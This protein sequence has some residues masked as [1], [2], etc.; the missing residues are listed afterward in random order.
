VTDTV[1]E[2]ELEAALQTY[3][4]AVGLARSGVKPGHIV[5]IRAIL[6]MRS[7]SPVEP[8]PML[9]FCPR[10]HLQHIDEPDER[11][12]DWTNPPHRSHLC[13]GCGCIWRPADV[14]TV[15]VAAIETKGKADN[16][17]AGQPAASPVDTGV[18]ERFPEIRGWFF[19]KLD[20]AQRKQFF[21]AVLNMR[22]DDEIRDRIELQ[23]QILRRLFEKPPASPVDGEVVERLQTGEDGSITLDNRSVQRLMDMNLLHYTEKGWFVGTWAALTAMK[24]NDRGALNPL[25]WAEIALADRTLG[26]SFPERDDGAAT[27]AKHGG[28]DG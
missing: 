21:A 6:A 1:T 15:G 13:H 11:T 23:H 24:A 14:A 7:A 27:K 22:A 2:A 28:S 8:L 17:D 26:L 20:E 16:F 3:C 19:H 12:P 10:C 18:D 5:G 9:L 25:V 4:D